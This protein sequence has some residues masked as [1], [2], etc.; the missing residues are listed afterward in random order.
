MRPLDEKSYCRVARE[1]RKVRRVNRVGQ[2][3]RRYVKFVFRSHMQ[4]RPAGN[5]Y[6]ELRASSQKIRHVKG[7]VKYLF[8]V[9][10]YQE[11]LLLLKSSLEAIEQELISRFIYI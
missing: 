8:K 7:C 11:Q 4:H 3:Q 6:L 5:K 9:V 2:S 10:Q 1:L